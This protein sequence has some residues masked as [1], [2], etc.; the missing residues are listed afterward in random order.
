M[1]ILLF[2]VVKVVKYWIGNEFADTVPDDSLLLLESWPGN[3]NKKISYDITS[4]KNCQ[5]NVMPEKTTKHVKSF[6]SYFLNLYK[7]I[8]NSLKITLK[9]ELHLLNAHTLKASMES[10]KSKVNNTDS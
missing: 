4:A 3:K 10:L 9:F 8:V 7:V 2:N 6:D 5:L 1:E